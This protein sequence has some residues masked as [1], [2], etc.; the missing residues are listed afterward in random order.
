MDTPYATRKLD[1]SAGRVA[2]QRV[3]VPLFGPA[4]RLHIEP[5]LF[6]Y[7]NGTATPTVVLAGGL[8]GL[9]PRRQ[10]TQNSRHWPLCYAP[11][12]CADPHNMGHPTVTKS[13]RRRKFES[14]RGSRQVAM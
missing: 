14:E 6:V 2:S 1:T 11:V 9:N 8:V 12:I 13:V 5:T 3:E 10:R 4:R 7:V